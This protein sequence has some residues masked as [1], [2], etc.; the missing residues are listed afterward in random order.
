MT[1]TTFP[2]TQHWT[3]DGFRVSVL[4]YKSHSHDR[5]Y[6]CGERG[7]IHSVWADQKADGGYS[8]SPTHF[9][10]DCRPR[11]G[12]LPDLVY[13]KHYAKGPFWTT[14]SL[15]PHPEWECLCGQRA[16]FHDEL[17]CDECDDPEFQE[18]YQHSVIPFRGPE[19]IESGY[20]HKRHNVVETWDCDDCRMTTRR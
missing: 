19:R 18:F 13:T 2:R 6:V 4:V 3:V 17:I 7:A 1:T 16:R 10:D 11:K 8:S 20:R 9:C 14:E 5:C 15:N 12:P